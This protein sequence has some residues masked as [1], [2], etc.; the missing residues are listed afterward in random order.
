[1]NGALHV[2]GDLLIGEG[3]GSGTLHLSNPYSSSRRKSMSATTWFSETACKARSGAKSIIADNKLALL[4]GSN[5][6][7]ANGTIESPTITL[8]G[9]AFLG[10]TTSP[11]YGS[12]GFVTGVNGGD[13]TIINGGTIDAAFGLTVTGDITSHGT[14]LIDDDLRSTAGTLT[15]N[16][17]I[18]GQ[19]I[20][21]AGT[22]SELL[23]DHF[24][25]GDGVQFF[26]AG[27]I[28]ASPGIQSIAY[29]PTSHTLS[30][31]KGG[32]TVESL[33]M[34]GDFTGQQF[35]LSQ[36]EFITLQ[37]AASQA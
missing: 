30:M 4:D 23:A 37:P 29:D 7:L 24:G 26:A 3:G 18:T 6:Q 9:M 11:T 36:N 25:V 15:V 2:G 10:G 34:V 16:G 1:M 20:Q 12:E 21:F 35:T 27:D 28:I 33:H 14:V 5:A 19:D 8:A 22:G 13:T 17:T 31:D 32:G